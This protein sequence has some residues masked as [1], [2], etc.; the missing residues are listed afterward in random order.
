[1]RGSIMVANPPDFLKMSEII[2]ARYRGYL[3]TMFYF[4]DPVL[5]DSFREA[6]ASENLIKGP[7]LEA[8]PV[9]VRSVTPRQLLAELGMRPDEGFLRAVQGDRPLYRH[10][11]EA[12][13]RI[14]SGRNVVVATGTGSGKTESFLLPILFHL[15][16][17]FT[18]GSLCPGVRALI[19]YPMNALSNDQ[20][21]RL[22]EIARRLEE[23]GSPFRFTFGQ[24]TGETPE[25][26]ND[27]ARNA[28]ERGRER[29]PGELVFRKEMRSS[30]P[31]ILLTNYSMLEYL[32]IR[33]DDSPLFDNGRACWWT[34]LVLDEAHQYRGTR[35][36]EMG[37]LLRRLKQRLRQGGRGLPFQCIATSATLLGGEADRGG[38]ADF[39]SA[40]FDEPFTPDDVIMGEAEPV[41]GQGR[42][43]LSQDDYRVIR[44]ALAAELQ[45]T[46]PALLALANRCGVQLS[47][48]VDPLRAAGHILAADTRSVGLRK[49]LSAGPADVRAIAEEIFPDVPAGERLSALGTL[50]HILSVASDPGAADGDTGMRPTLLAP[51]YH[52]FLRS[53]EG[54]FISY[55]PEKR[56]F[57]N[58]RQGGEG[59]SFEVALCRE[60][61]Q[62]YLVGKMGGESRAGY[63]LEAVRDPSH[64]EFGVDFLLPL[65]DQGAQPEGEE[66]EGGDE[67]EPRRPSSDQEQLFN[68]CLRCRAYWRE[69]LPPS[70]EHGANPGAVLRVI[71]Q[72]VTEGQDALRRCGAC[73]YRGPDPVQE[74]IHGADG[75]S[76]VIATTLYEVLPPETRKVLA[77]ADGRQEA[78]F[79]AWYLQRTYEDLFFRNLMLKAARRLMPHSPEGLSLRDLADE[80]QA[81]MSREGIAPAHTSPIELRRQA[82]RAV[83]REFLTTEKRICLEGTGLSHW[84]IRW[85]PWFRVPPVLLGEPWHLS[86]DEAWDLMFMLL[87]S[88]RE[89]RAVELVADTALTLTWEQ[90]SLPLPTR[91]RIGAPGKQKRVIAW[92]GPRGAR[93]KLLKKILIH[94]GLGAE[95]AESWALR[96]LRELWQA[97]GDFD[98]MIPDSSQGLL[99]VAGGDGRR[100]NPNWWRFR[101]LDPSDPVLQCERCGV[102]EAPVLIGWWTV[103][104]VRLS[105]DR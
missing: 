84:S 90:F 50:V 82:W 81:I 94:R 30:P 6:L 89:T 93:A 99:L 96:T 97:F 3:E 92:D 68:L 12:I 14:V 5:R 15:Y 44:E 40:L 17:E 69:G 7:Y 59:A 48:N 32:L 65:E 63:F 23:A 10:Q 105:R 103:C 1:M 2:G 102:R 45:E 11:E 4:R 91:F 85:P 57:L 60:C 71:R 31:H 61:G 22:G 56:I 9:F 43:T 87:N 58:R 67:E 101:A 24:Y 77:F 73:G 29:L 18:A 52:V 72:P 46:P 39:A 104:P 33:P 36:M 49:P 75:P 21:D 78:A 28:K 26:E 35:G 27:S 38:A 66:G 64:S 51:R 37:M 54:A 100:L 62:H 79:F 83:F 53:L 80:L 42:Y 13:R 98:R 19:L 47:P 25:D 86:E 95:E 70:C 20:R 88:M 76:A 34:F 55:L 41:R 16:R 74:V 8:T